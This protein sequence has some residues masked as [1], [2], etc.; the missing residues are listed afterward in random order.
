MIFSGNSLGAG[1]PEVKELWRTTLPK[2]AIRYYV[3]AVGEDNSWLISTY[4]PDYF[5]WINSSGVLLD[6]FDQLPMD[7]IDVISVSSTDLNYLNKNLS[8]FYV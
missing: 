7:D 4:A 1:F 5:A 6:S 3:E 8:L 2:V